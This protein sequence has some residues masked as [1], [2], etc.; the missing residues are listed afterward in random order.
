MIESPVL[1]EWF[2]ER[3]IK[4]RQLVIL[5]SLE[6]KFGAP[7]SPSTFAAVRAVHDEEQLKALLRIVCTCPT[8]DEFRQALAAPAT[9]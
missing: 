8:L 9:N 3:D 5:E 2:A 1:Q 6:A 4:L 7:A